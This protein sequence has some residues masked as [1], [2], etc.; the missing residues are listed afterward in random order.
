MTTTGY[1][2]ADYTSWGTGITILFFVLTFTGACAGSTSGNI[3]I[4]RHLVFFKNSILEFKRLVHP[5]GM[6]RVKIDSQLV[7]PKILT[8]ILVFLLLYLILFVIGSW[9]MAFMLNDVEEPF[10]TAIGSVASC[11]GNVG[12]AIGSVGPVHNFGIIPPLGKCLLS[13]YMIVGRLELFTVL[14]I[15]SPYFWRTN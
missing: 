10:L 4:L 12:P 1:C 14:I 6:I 3:K 8:H 7:A 5:R 2:T 9:I 13:F 15:F 11:L